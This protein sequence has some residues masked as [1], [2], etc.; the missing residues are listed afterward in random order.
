MDNC[1]TTEN[2]S[3]FMIDIF[4]SAA[5]SRLTSPGGAGATAADVLSESNK[6]FQ[7][8]FP[9]Q[10][11]LRAIQVEQAL[12][13]L[14]SAARAQLSDGTQVYHAAVVRPACAEARSADVPNSVAELANALQ[15]AQQRHAQLL[16]QRERLARSAALLQDQQALHRE[17]KKLDAAAKTLHNME[18]LVERRA[19]KTSQVISSGLQ[20]K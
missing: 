4:V 7:C 2:C 11:P 3:L 5:L 14:P 15:A 12:A 1:S 20:Q 18:L 13:R 8:V 19:W 6:C 9:D 16:E 10:P 17:V